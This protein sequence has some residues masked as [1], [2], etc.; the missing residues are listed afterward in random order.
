MKNTILIGMLVVLASSIGAQGPA[1][2]TSDQQHLDALLQQVQAQQRQIAENQA[3]IDAKLAS[4]AEAIRVA[5]IY[6]SRG[7]H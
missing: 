6:A 1:P 2:I 7:G 3:N 4:L 5:R